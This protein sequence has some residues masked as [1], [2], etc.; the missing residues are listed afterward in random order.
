LATHIYGYLHDN[1]YREQSLMDSLAKSSIPTF[2]ESVKVNTKTGSTYKYKNDFWT[3]VE[4]NFLTDES[5]A[6]KISLINFWFPGCK[7]CIKSIPQKNELVDH[8]IAQPNFQ[9]LNINCDFTKSTWIQYLERYD[10]KGHY[11]LT[12]FPTYMLVVDGSVKRIEQ[13]P[14]GSE[15]LFQLIDDALDMATDII[16]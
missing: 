6:N 4:G 1:P 16:E 3:D 9:F 10:M 8:Y 7:P 2:V 11:E 15:E 13:Y 14:I 12:A 5:L